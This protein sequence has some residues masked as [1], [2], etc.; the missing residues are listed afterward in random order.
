MLREFAVTDTLPDDRVDI[1][2]AVKS[3]SG[4]RGGTGKLE[5]LVRDIA[6]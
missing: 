5:L 3:A 6:A 2:E 4:W 1:I